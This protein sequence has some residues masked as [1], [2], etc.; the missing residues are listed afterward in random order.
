[1]SVSPAGARRS[2]PQRID[3][4]RVACWLAGEQLGGDTVD[5]GPPLDERLGSTAMPGRALAGAELPVHAR[6]HERVDEGER[7]RRREDRRGCE[8]VR[9][10]GR[11][12]LV[13]LR[14]PGGR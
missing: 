13:Q 11:A 6:A 3:S 2:S 10:S 12:G 1:V 4:V 9:R 8:H 14:H 7:P 5:V